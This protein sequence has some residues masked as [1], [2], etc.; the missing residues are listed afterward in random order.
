M[1]RFFR[2]IRQRLITDNKFSKYLLYAV[3]EILLVVIGILIAI[4]VDNWNEERQEKERLNKHLIELKSSLLKD[5]KDLR[6]FE[7][8]NLFRSR[9][10][11]YVIKQTKGEKLQD[12]DSLTNPTLI[13]S[14]HYGQIDKNAENDELEL[15][16]IAAEQLPFQVLMWP[17]KEAFEELKNTGNFSMI[18]DTALK[19]NINRYYVQMDWLFNSTR[20]SVAMEQIEQWKNHIIVHHGFLTEDIG[21]TIDWEVIL[22]DP[23]TL[24]YVRDISNTAQDRAD[25]AWQVKVDAWKLI[26]VLDER[27]SEETQ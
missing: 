27:L 17:N 24:L 13:L 3:G 5:I 23:L 14:L 21:K 8:V 22:N 4:Q 16:R 2:Q 25:M 11:N 20:K 15:F 12:S 18:Q 7:K 10:I 19:N 1:L 6:G 26:K 9:S